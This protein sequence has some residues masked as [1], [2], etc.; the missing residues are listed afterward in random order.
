MCPRPKTFLKRSR[1][2]LRSHRVDSLKGG[3]LVVHTLD[4]AKLR[5]EELSQVLQDVGL[6]RP[7]RAVM[8]L[9]FLRYPAVVVLPSP[10]ALRSNSPP[11]G[12][13]VQDFFDNLEWQANPRTRLTMMELA[14]LCFLRQGFQPDVMSG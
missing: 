12:G 6:A 1:I 3:R 9:P 8:P 10:Y 14:L 7:R 11:P 5:L 2:S 13:C 4:V